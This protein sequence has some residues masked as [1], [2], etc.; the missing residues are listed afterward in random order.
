LL[1]GK[2]Q[3]SSSKGNVINLME[4]LKTSWKIGEKSGEAEAKMAKRCSVDQ[5]C[6]TRQ[7]S[8]TA[9]AGLDRRVRWRCDAG[10]GI[11]KI[12]HRVIQGF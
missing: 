7:I 6:A 10:V 5:A 3:R 11:A 8:L 9:A 1:G 12:P 4:A 2:L